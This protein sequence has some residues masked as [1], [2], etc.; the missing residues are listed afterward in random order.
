VGTRS[1]ANTV[2]LTDS[3]AA[4]LS[5]SSISTTTGFIQTNTCTSPLLPGKSCS[6]SVKFAPT[7]IGTITGSLTIN[8]NASNNPQVVGLN[9]KGVK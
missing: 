8:D 3:G 5:V 2:R 7:T 9:G 4:S 6:I 1:A